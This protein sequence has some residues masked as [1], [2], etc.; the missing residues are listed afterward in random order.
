MIAYC[1]EPNTHLM[2]LTA[3][4]TAGPVG[5]SDSI[6]HINR[7]LVMHTAREDGYYSLLSFPFLLFYFIYILLTFY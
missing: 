7:D 1:N 4:L 3:A 2:A 6:G 5:P